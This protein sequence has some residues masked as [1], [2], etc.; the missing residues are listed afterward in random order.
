MPSPDASEAA[1]VVGRVPDTVCLN[2]LLDNE[3]D[4]EILRS[5]S[6]GGVMQP[7]LPPDPRRQEAGR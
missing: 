6:Y 7:G 5:L 4:L 3:V 1:L 2:G